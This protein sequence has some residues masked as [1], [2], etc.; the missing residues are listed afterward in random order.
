MKNALLVTGATGSI[1]ENLVEILNREDI[2]PIITY[3]NNR[4]KAEQLSAKYSSPSIFLNLQNTESINNLVN[5]I[6]GLNFNLVGIVL[7]ASPNFELKPF[8]SL[9]LD[10]IYK[11]FEVNVVG[12]HKLL[13]GMVKKIFKKNKKG[14]VVGVLSEAMG[15]PLNASIKNMTPYIVSKYGLLGLLSSLK[16]EYE[17]LSVDTISP[18]F[19]ESNML[20]SFDERFLNKMRKNNQIDNP[21][22]AA[23]KI[24]K[25]VKKNL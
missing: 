21:Q 22:N 13:S 14:I 11:Q 8:T 1:G 12:N 2:V 25:I 5:E 23:D 17:W 3:N 24:F 4:I 20:K 16:K 9:N 15:K 19:T 6:S 7:C 10:Q 18:S